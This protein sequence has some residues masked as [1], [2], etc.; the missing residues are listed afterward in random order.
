M[1]ASS[2]MTNSSRALVV[3]ACA[4]A[5]MVAVS[6]LPSLRAGMT[7]L[8][9]GCCMTDYFLID[10]PAMAVIPVIAVWAVV[11]T[12]ATIATIAVR[13]GQQQSEPAAA[14]RP[15]MLGDEVPVEEPGEPEL[16]DPELGDP[17][18]GDPELGDP[19]LGDPELGEPELGEPELGVPELGELLLGVLV[20]GAVPGVLVGPAL[21][22]VVGAAFGVVVGVALGAEGVVPFGAEGVVPFGVRLG[23]PFGAV[24]DVDLGAAGVVL[25]GAVGVVPFGAVLGGVL[26][27]AD[28]AVGAW[29]VPPL[30][31]ASTFGRIRGKGAGMGLPPKRKVLSVM[32]FSTVTCDAGRVPEKRSRPAEAPREA[33]V[34]ESERTGAGFCLGRDLG[35]VSFGKAAPPPK[36]N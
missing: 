20:V 30:T 21:G 16:G 23:V 4:M 35:A 15:P 31:A 17:E 29:L 32:G 13:D 26:G 11:D 3:R 9:S 6:L 1:E 19:E 33:P 10:M 34:R 24:G 25:L 8:M 14:A 2:T 18:L 36:L 27:D 22:V 7:T 28:G 12:W 5:W